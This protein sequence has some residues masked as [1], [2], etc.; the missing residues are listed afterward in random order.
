MCLALYEFVGLQ[1]G[2]HALSLMKLL[3][4]EIELP[5]IDDNS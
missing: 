2:A 3:G 4:D 1:Q 5:N